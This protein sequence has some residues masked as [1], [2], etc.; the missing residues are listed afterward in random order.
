MIDLA[1]RGKLTNWLKGQPVQIS[2]TLAARAA[3]RV[4][5]ALGVLSSKRSVPKDQRAKIVL[6]VFR[7]VA[8]GLAAARYR[9]IGAQNAR[10]AAAAAADAAHDADADTATRAAAFAAAHVAYAAAADA[11]ATG[12]S[13]TAADARAAAA[14]AAARTADAARTAAAVAN[15]VRTAVAARTANAAA[16]ANAADAAFIRSG[17]SVSALAARPLWPD[18]IPAWAQE[19]WDR[20]KSGLPK[21]ER[22]ETWTRWYEAR[23]DGKEPVESLERHRVLQ[24]QDF[25]R[26]S[27]QKINTAIEA[28]ERRWRALEPRPAPFDYHVIGGKIDVAP[29]AARSINAKTSLDLQAES[30]RKARVLKE[31]LERMQ[32]DERLRADIEMLLERLTSSVLRPGLILSS[33]RSLEAINRAYDSAEGREELSPNAL[34]DIFDLTNT[35]KE[36]AATFPNSREIEAEA[37][38][39]GLPLERLDDIEQPIARAAVAIYVS[40]GATAATKESVEATASAIG[41]SRDLAGRAKQVAYHLLDIG[42]IARAGLRHLKSTGQRIVAP[43]AETAQKVGQEVGGLAADTWKVFRKDFPKRAGRVA[44]VAIVGG[45]GGLLHYLGMEFQAIATAVTAFAPIDET[46]KEL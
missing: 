26:Q 25:W 30:V 34:K 21:T 42:N 44:S 13:R 41:T 28:E 36:F 5:P 29:E 35:I 4:L 46:I 37:V 22:W 40:D 10:V 20:L 33:L 31:R 3:A 14:D 23:R 32:A 39:L 8:A 12:N 6:P 7:A 16:D 38:S 19:N 9:F 11:R 43:S 2:V 17:G 1:T 24:D 15:A 45:V 27:P 18:G